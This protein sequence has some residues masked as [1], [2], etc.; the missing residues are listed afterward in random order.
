MQKKQETKKRTKKERIQDRLEKS[1]QIPSYIL[2]K[3]LGAQLS[4]DVSCWTHT[5]SDGL[6]VIPLTAE[7]RYS[8]D[9]RG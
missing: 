2:D 1:Y 4:S 9:A 8:F 3:D 7:Q 6:P 5:N